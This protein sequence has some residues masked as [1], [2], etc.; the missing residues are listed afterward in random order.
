MDRNQRHLTMRCIPVDDRPYEK[1]MASGPQAL[2]DAELMAIII[3]SGSQQD[4]ALSLCQRLLAADQNSRGLAFLQDKSLEELMSFQ[5]IGQVK[6]AQL[7]A[8]LEIGSRAVSAASRQHHKFIKS[9]QDAIDLLEREMCQLSREELRIVLL[10]IRNKVIR[11]CRVAEG[12]L[13]AAVIHPRDLFREAIKAN[14]AALVLAHNHPS[15]NSTPSHDDL[16][17]T[18]R[19][20][21]AGDMMGVRVVDHII[22][23]SGGSTSLKQCGLI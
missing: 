22:L 18:R 5:G 10:D 4:T 11:V 14:A 17:T 6:A 15:G 13:A 7:K 12:G 1:M 9:P 3:R 20:V 16:E 19:L 2:T 23:A 21:E 8:A